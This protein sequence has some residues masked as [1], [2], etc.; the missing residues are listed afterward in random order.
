MSVYSRVLFLLLALSPIYVSLA[1]PFAF[2]QLIVMNSSLPGYIV[3]LKGGDKIGSKLT[4]FITQLPKYGTLF[5]LS[6]VY[7]LYGYH[8]VSGMPITDNH[9]FVTGSLHRVY[10]VPN[11][12]LFCRF[13][14]DMF[15]FIVTDGSTHSFPGN[16]TMVDS[17][18]TIVGS[19]F[20]LGN[21][22]WTI[23]GNKLPVSVPVFEPYSRDQFFHHYIQAS[24]NLV[25][26]KPDKSLWVF[27]APSK[28]L[29]NFGIAYGGT[30]QF[31]IS[32]LAG[33]VTQL[34]KG[35]PLVELECNKTG[36]T[37]VYPLSAVQFVHLIASFQI[38]LVESSGWLKVSR[39]DLPFGKVL[40]SKCEFIQV[41]SCVSGFRILGD[42]TTWYETIALDNVFI[43]NGRN[44][45]L[46]DVSCN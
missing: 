21:D 23:L 29:G 5:Q 24:D 17:D 42:L 39:D 14:S 32:L 12:R 10:Y 16:V 6:Q 45:F 44:H 11:T 41:L 27:N 8:P 26:G 33:D 35:A 31:S 22:G 28:F 7:S 36:I 15:S 25:H 13:C 19:D 9:T 3:R 30:I 38:A 18:G 4:T 46:L 37:L 40:P 2:H 43:R 34:H 1:V 20:L